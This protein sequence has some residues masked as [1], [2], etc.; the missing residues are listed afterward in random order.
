MERTMYSYIHEEL[1]IIYFISFLVICRS[2]SLIHYDPDREDH[3]HFEI[4]TQP[5]EKTKKAKPR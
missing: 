1:C 2:L 5:K 4:K 3:S